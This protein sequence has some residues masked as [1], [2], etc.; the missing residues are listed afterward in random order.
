MPKQNNRAGEM[1]EACEIGGVPL[2]PRHEAPR[3]LKPGEEPLHFPAPLIAAE[4]APIL[5]EI[6]A[7]G[8]VRRDELDP[9]RRKGPVQA[10][11]VIGPVA[12]E[13]S[14]II[15]QKAGV[16]RLGDESGFVRGRRGDGNGDRKTSAVCDCHDLGPFT[17]LGVADVAAFFLALAKEPS[18]KVSLKSK[19]PRAWRSAASALSTRRRIPVSTHC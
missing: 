4:W 19:P 2:V 10:V 16:Q 11:A 9:T 18:M 7:I 5:R 14:W 1:Q 13:A 3:V 15:G 6:D 12:D 17:A 8:P